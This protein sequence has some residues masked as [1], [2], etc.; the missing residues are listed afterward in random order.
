MRSSGRLWRVDLPRLRK[1]LRIGLPIGATLLFEVSLFNAAAFL[2]GLFGAEPLAAHFIALQIATMSFM[3]PLGLAQAATVRVGL[4]FGAGDP[5]GVRRAGWTAFALGV[6]FMALWALVLILAPRTLLGAFLDSR[7]PEGAAVI[8]IAVVFLAFAALFQVADGAQAVG[9]GMLRGLGDTRVPMV[10]AAVG[11]WAIG[12]TLG[13]ALAFA[14]GLGASGIWIGLSTGLTVVAAL[15]LARWL[16]RGEL[17]LLGP[18]LPEL[19]HAR[20]VAA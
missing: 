5:D 2:M 3:I 9:A 4:A 19:L 17:G 7:D 1:L 14:T 15:M 13:V 11:Y 6:G 20:S 18:P 16:R 10:Y 8:E 12:G